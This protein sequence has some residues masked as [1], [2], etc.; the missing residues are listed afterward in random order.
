[1][2]VP[3]SGLVNSAV[4]DGWWVVVT[5]E[6]LS[7]RLLCHVYKQKKQNKTKQN[8]TK[9]KQKNKKTFHTIIT[10]RRKPCLV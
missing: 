3:P 8:K 9:Q 6:K 10:A 7:R 5:P 2:L 4:K 1:M